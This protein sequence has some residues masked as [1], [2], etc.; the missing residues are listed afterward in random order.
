MACGRAGPWLRLYFWTL[1]LPFCGFTQVYIYESSLT[2]HGDD[3]R[4]SS[5]VALKA[6]RLIKASADT[7]GSNRQSRLDVVPGRLS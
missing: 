5:L 3:E 6:L 4:V 2:A 1:D 7:R